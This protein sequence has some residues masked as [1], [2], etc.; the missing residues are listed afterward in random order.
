MKFA[1]KVKHQ[2]EVPLT[3]QKTDSEFAATVLLRF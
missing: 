1:I 3:R 2:T